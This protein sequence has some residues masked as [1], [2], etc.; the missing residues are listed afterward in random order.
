MIL[1]KH[2]WI[3]KNESSIS[4]MVRYDRI[5]TWDIPR[6]ASAL[7]TEALKEWGRLLLLM[8]AYMGIFFL[9][10]AIV[11]WLKTVV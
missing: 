8:G 11:L 4:P 7:N 9:L 10:L 2:G 6:R 1:K 3:E 5:P